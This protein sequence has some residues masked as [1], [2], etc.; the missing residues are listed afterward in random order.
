MYPFLLLGRMSLNDDVDLEVFVMA[1]DELSGADIKGTLISDTITIR[2]QF[3]DRSLSLPL[4]LN[5]LICP[6]ATTPSQYPPLIPPTPYPPLDPPLWYR[7]YPLV[8]LI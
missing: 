5:I 3:R 2:I 8:D 7:Y 1:K 4:P 6:S